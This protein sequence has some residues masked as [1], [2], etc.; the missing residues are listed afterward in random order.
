MMQIIKILDTYPIRNA[1]LLGEN[2]IFNSFF[3]S[4]L[5]MLTKHGVHISLY[6]ELP[7]LKAAGF[8]DVA[9]MLASYKIHLMVH[10][11]TLDEFDIPGWGGH[12]AMK[13]SIAALQNLNDLGYGL[14]QDLPLTVVY[15]I[16][17]HCSDPSIYTPEKIAAWLEERLAVTAN[18]VK[19]LQAR[20]G[21]GSGPAY[22]EPEYLHRLSKL[23]EQF[24]PNQ[25]GKL[26]CQHSL[27][28]TWNGIFFDCQS[29]AMM[30]KT[31]ADNMPRH[32]LSFDE[33]LNE[34]PIHINYNCLA[35]LSKNGSSL[36]D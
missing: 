16:P 12:E 32:I 2:T 35:C 25:L 15:Y 5:D 29:N 19:V 30:E 13:R 7:I 34:R 6:T 28:V 10:L 9:A 20:P 31:L 3:H 23:M 11:P 26:Q 22:S 21:L 1:T 17:N 24:D 18:T 14:E 4:L 27:C 8:T 33:S 36:L